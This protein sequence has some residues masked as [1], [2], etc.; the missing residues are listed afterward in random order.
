MVIGKSVRP[1]H[2]DSLLQIEA[3]KK[4]PGAAPSLRMEPPN[5]EFVAAAAAVMVT[6]AAAL[7]AHALRPAQRIPRP[8]EF[9]YHP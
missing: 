1:T 6:S 9:R 3:L 5:P 2:D 7:P 8:A 4:R